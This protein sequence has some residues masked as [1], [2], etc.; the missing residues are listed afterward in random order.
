MTALN[1]KISEKQRGTVKSIEEIERLLAEHKTELMAK[2]AIKEIGAFGSFARGE[3]TEKS[4]EDI[5]IDFYKIPD[6]FKFIEIERV[7]EEI[8][9]VKVDLVRKPALRMELKDNIL[10]EVIPV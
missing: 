3:Q 8:I 4:D 5:L 7:I 6:L 1:T 10:R 9:G 2:Y